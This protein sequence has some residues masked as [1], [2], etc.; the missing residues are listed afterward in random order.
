VAQTGLVA[1]E[2]ARSQQ[3][4]YAFVQ[5]MVETMRPCTGR[6]VDAAAKFR[7]VLI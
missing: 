7:R 4:N 5:H 2:G 1:S 3:D 6:L